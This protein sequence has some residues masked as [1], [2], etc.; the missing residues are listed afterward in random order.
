MMAA[1]DSVDLAALKDN[2]L[3]ESSNGTLSNGVGEHVFAGR[4]NQGVGSDKRRVVMAFDIAGAIPAGSKI[5]SVVLTLHLSKTRTGTSKVVMK[6]LT[7]DWGEGI[8]NDSGGEGSGAPATDGDATWKHTFYDD[9]FWDNPGGDF[10]DAESASTSVGGTT[11]FY[12]WGPTDHL[13]ADVQQ[14]LDDPSGGFGWVLIGDESVQRSAKRFDSR[15]NTTRDNRPKLTVEY[16]PDPCF[17]Q[18]RADSNCDGSV[19]F[20]DIDC[21]VGALI[22]RSSWD[23][24]GHGQACGYACVNDVNGDG[25]VD[26]NDIDAFVEC[27]VN[28]G[29]P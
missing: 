19:D 20:D 2:T 29:C 8:S 3:Y 5:D 6:R 10:V 4:T 18:A 7:R 21:F 15:E 11:G 12:K 13:V 26:F 23:S 25:N 14:M 17:G 22:G 27:L 16:T 24:C 1:A 9:Q 28:G